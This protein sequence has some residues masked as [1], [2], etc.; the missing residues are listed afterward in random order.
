MIGVLLFSQ[1]ARWAQWVGI[2]IG[3]VGTVLLITVTANGSFTFNSYALLVM[4]ATVC[5]G[6][7][8]NLIKHKIADLKPLTITGV[9][10]LMASIPA[11]IFLFLGT[12]F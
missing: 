5:Y 7:N 8:L 2:V 12:D 1:S 6:I 9:S 11:A 4:L 10:L 3:L